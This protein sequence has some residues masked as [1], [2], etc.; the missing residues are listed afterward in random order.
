MTGQA[1]TRAL[2][3]RIEV[4]PGT[5]FLR[6]RLVNLDRLMLSSP[7]RPCPSGQ[8][9]F[10]DRRTDEVLRWNQS[11]D[12]GQAVRPLSGTDNFIIGFR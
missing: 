3:L 6:K 2:A 11:P 8:G 12:A 4:V 5:K 10:F 7:W 1:R 9:E